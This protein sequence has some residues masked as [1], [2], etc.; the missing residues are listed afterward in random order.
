MSTKDALTDEEL[1]VYSRQ[2]VLNEIGYEGQVKLK[3]GKVLLAGAG[4]LG[5][6]V[7]LQLAAMGIGYLK[8]VD[9]DIVSTS[10][11]HRQ[12]LY[13]VNDIGLPKVEAASSRLEALNPR[14]KIEPIPISIK[15]WNVEELIEGVDVVVDG[16]DSMEARYLINSACV[17]KNV[18]Y[19]YCGAITALGNVSTIIPGKTPCL[20]CIVTGIKDTDLPK[21]AV[22]GVYTP[23][24][25]I[26]ASIEVSE[27]VKLLT[28]KEPSFAGKLFYVDA[29][30]GNFHKISLTRNDTC[31]IC[32]SGAS[33][34]V[35]QINENLIEEQCSRKGERSLVITPKKHLPVDIAKAV[36]LLNGSGYRID[37][38]GQLGATLTDKNGITV[39]IMK[40]GV[41]IIQIPPKAKIDNE[42]LFIKELI[43]DKLRLEADA[44]PV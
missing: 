43:V 42:A 34:V 6:P 4:G 24:I 44:F 15:S 12:Y 19:I 20:E 41:S 10:D 13:D 28:G 32:G 26:V 36:D 35:T 38:R 21:C 30:D 27:A 40:T 2:I 33:S 3:A 18:P 37:A 23:V 9:R 5:T 25:G 16:L 8:I 7:A 31:S 17:K 29:S 39:T 11:L 14:I 22:V 1:C